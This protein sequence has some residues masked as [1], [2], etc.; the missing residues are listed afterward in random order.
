MTLLV[1]L[2][3]EILLPC[4]LLGI[5][6][7]F[8]L[9]RKLVLAKRLLGGMLSALI[10]LSMPVVSQNLMV[11]LEQLPLSESSA[12]APQAIVILGAGV[13]VAEE[14][15]GYT[16][17]DICL[18]RVRYGAGIARRSKLPVLVTGGNS[19]DPHHSEAWH[20][21]KVMTEEF[22]QPARWIEEESSNTL[23][24][25]KHSAILLKDNNINMILL[26]TTASHMMR[27]KTAFE[28]AGIK[29][30]PAP[31]SFTK[32]RAF[33]SWLSYVP[34]ADSLVYLRK[35]LH[36]LIGLVFYRLKE[37]SLGI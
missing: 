36:E 13:T 3:I 5:V 22:G 32:P 27:A 4:L 12:A 8:L 37:S 30:V 2:L 21:R 10:V 17:D 9:N 16:C 29:V 6:G 35:L 25:A 34:T 33:S 23:E 1:N 14:Y 19:S 24:N 7:Y 28:M 26:I 18:Q 15:G 11:W 31:T 20:M